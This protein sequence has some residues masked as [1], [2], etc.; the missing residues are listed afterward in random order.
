MVS[1]KKNF[2]FLKTNSSPKSLLRNSAKLDTSEGTCEQQFSE[3]VEKLT[4]R[5]KKIE[6]EFQRYETNFGFR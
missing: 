2:D 4:A 5:A 3:V 6:N 1:L